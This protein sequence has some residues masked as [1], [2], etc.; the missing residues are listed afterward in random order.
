MGRSNRIPAAL[1]IAAVSFAASMAVAAPQAQKAR[2]EPDPSLKALIDK[3]QAVQEKIQTLRVEF[4]Q[5]NEFEML[6]EPQ[7]FEGKLVLK[8][9]STA[10]Y[11]YHKPDPLYFQ[12]KDGWLL[13]YDPSKKEASYQDIRRHE[14]R[15]QRYLDISS[16]LKELGKNFDIALEDEKD[17]LAHLKLT[18]KKRRAKKKIQEMHFF[19]DRETGTIGRFEIVEASGDAIAFDFRNWE[20]NPELSDEDFEVKIPQGVKVTREKPD[21]SQPFGVGK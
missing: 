12:V 19:V 13:V 11:A 10:L 16:P 20:I 15:I 5:T 4:T 6:S 2:A 14:G 9:P 7:V 21:L 1:L 8:K 3:V 18:P 17:G